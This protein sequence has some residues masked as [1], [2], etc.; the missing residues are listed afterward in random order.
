MIKIQTMMAL[1]LTAIA[2]AVFAHPGHPTLSPY[3]IHGPL[4][5]DPIG[6]ILVAAIAVGVILIRRGEMR[7]RPKSVRIRKK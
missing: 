1:L 5:L 6:V 4:E 2:P 3:H 7:R